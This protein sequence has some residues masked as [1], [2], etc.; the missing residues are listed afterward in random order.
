MLAVWTQGAE[1]NPFRLATVWRAN[2]IELLVMAR[3]SETI[4]S[5]PY[6]YQ[7]M[8]Q[9]GRSRFTAAGMM[10]HSGCSVLCS[11]SAEYFRRLPFELKVDTAVVA[12]IS[13]AP[14]T[15]QMAAFHLRSI[16]RE[17]TTNRGNIQR[18]GNPNT[19]HLGQISSYTVRARSRNVGARHCDSRSDDRT[20]PPLPHKRRRRQRFLKSM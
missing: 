16:M 5:G 8:V 4:A 20:P 9:H 17:R 18:L 13:S 6:Y 15:K 3:G 7:R 2:S 11:T 1:R 12:P 14:I 19:V 10:V